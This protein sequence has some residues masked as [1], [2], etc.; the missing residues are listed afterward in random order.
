M[1]LPRR[2]VDLSHS[3][4]SPNSIGPAENDH[5]VGKHEV[6]CQIFHE[7]GPGESPGA[8]DQDVDDFID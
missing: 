7:L 1:C 5:F 4:R 8:L 3:A 2:Q 6:V